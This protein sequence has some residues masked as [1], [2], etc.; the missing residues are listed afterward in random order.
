VIE[1]STVGCAHAAEDCG[2]VKAE[3][4]ERAAKE[5][6]LFEAITTGRAAEE[7]LLDRV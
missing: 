5:R 3:R 2:D 6:V 4:G 1:C 7:L